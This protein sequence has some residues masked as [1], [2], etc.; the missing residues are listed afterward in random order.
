MYAIASI[1]VTILPMNRDGTNHI[2]PVQPWF[3][4]VYAAL[5][6]CFWPTITYETE[7]L[8]RFAKKTIP[9][10]TGFKAYPSR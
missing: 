9:V 10:Y 4:L 5:I 3:A 6:F 1:L 8:D 2:K 7:T